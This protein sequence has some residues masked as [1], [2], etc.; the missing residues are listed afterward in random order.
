MYGSFQAPMISDTP[1]GSRRTRTWPGCMRSGVGW[2]S[3]FTQSWMWSSAYCASRM[4]YST[5]IRSLS[6]LLRRR[7]WPEALVHRVAALVDH[8]L[9]RLELA[10]PPLQG[11]AARLEVRALAGNQAR[12]VR[13]RHVVPLPLSGPHLDVACLLA[14]WCASASVAG[15]RST[16]PVVTSNREPWHWHMMVV[17]VSS[18]ADSGQA[19]CVQRSSKAYS[20]PPTRATDDAALADRRGSTARRSRRA[21][22]RSVRACGIVGQ[23][24]WRSPLAAAQ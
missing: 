14:D 16:A 13:C 7:S 19:S 12:V 11:V 15:P 20:L 24:G 5:S 23:L 3:T 21:A 1:S 4:E 2:C 18:P 6:V 8:H 10:D 9:D 22:R 17:P